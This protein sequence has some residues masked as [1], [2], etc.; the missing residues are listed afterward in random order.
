MNKGVINYVP[1]FLY[2]K[3][4]TT[5]I[6]DRTVYNSYSSTFVKTYIFTLTIAFNP[7]SSKH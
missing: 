2:R 5:R 3:P 7:L 6:C 4:I 1:C